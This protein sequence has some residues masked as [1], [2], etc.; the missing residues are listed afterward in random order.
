VQNKDIP[1]VPSEGMTTEEN[2]AK[3]S[4]Q[5]KRQNHLM[6]LLRE[7]NI[8]IL[9]LGWQGNKYKFNFGTTKG[10]CVFK[11]LKFKS[12]MNVVRVLTW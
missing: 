4:K 3:S 6:Q 11:T 8:G 1:T 2:M 7:K 9:G 10:T 12:M 5:G